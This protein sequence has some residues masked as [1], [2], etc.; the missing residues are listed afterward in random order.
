MI[1]WEACPPVHSR[2]QFS[3]PQ[4]RPRSDGIDQL[5]TQFPPSAG[6]KPAIVAAT[7]VSGMAGV[8]SFVK[9][10]I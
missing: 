10:R 7:L 8:W 5:L 6:V 3:S 4:V 9:K 2:A 1:P